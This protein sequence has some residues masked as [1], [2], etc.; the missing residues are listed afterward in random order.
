MARHIRNLI[1]LLWRNISLN[2]YN[3]VYE[4]EISKE[5]ELFKDHFRSFRNDYIPNGSFSV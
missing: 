5:I 1:P 4:Y 3:L 2:L